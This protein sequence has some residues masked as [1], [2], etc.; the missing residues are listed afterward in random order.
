MLMTIIL[1]LT[2]LGAIGL[3]IKIFKNKGEIL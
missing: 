1:I 2:I 3:V